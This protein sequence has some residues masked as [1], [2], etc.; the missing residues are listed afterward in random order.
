MRQYLPVLLAFATITFALNPLQNE[1]E[2]L[3]KTN[4]ALRNALKAMNANS[5]VMVG[6]GDFFTVDGNGC[7]VSSNCVSSKNYPS[8][9][10]NHEECTVK[11]V[12]DAKLTV[13]DPFDIERNYDFL[14]VKNQ[15]KWT[16]SEFPSILI[17]G[18]TITWKT[19]YSVSKSGWE[20]CF[21]SPL[22]EESNQCY[23]YTD[24]ASTTFESCAE[25]NVCVNYKREWWNLREGGIASTN[26]Y[27]GCKQADFCRSFR[28][29]A[30]LYG[31]TTGESVP[32]CTECSTDKCNTPRN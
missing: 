11:I 25:G 6:A 10:G 22:E 28:L 12:K 24:P 8:K 23:S 3:K 19:D 16:A 2:Q 29:M 17:S 27:G 31:S 32:Y 13:S 4:E 9:H 5:E 1:N 7:D 15:A 14:H 20:I 26:L 30:D 21:S 18:D